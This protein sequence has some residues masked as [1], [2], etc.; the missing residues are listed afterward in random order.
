M[1]GGRP[2]PVALGAA[3]LNAWTLAIQR[4]LRVRDELAK[5]RF[6]DLH[7]HELIENPLA[8]IEST[9]AGLEMSLSEAARDRMQAHAAANPRGKHGAHHYALADWGLDDATVRRAFDF[10]VD[11]CDVRIES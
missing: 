11:R 2:D 7:F 4:T 1:T 8:A 5:S 6:V 3:E 10:Y 9:Y